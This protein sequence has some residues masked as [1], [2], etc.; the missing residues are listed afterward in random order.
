MNWQEFTKRAIFTPFLDHGRSYDGWDCWGL[1]YIAYRDVLGVDIPSYDEAYTD[2]G[3]FKE[4]HKA[5]SS[6][7]D[8]WKKK[9]ETGSV[10]LILR[11]NLPIHVGILVGKSMV[12][13]CEKSV[14][15]IQ[16]PRANMRIEGC[17]A[18]AW[19]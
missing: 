8:A 13:H 12:L 1:V 2:T 18:P 7:L 3:K 5:F 16:E 11:R 10:A 4:L 6:G 14:G 9:D 17:Y 15:T 19:V